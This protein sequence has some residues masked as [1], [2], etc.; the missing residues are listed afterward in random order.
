MTK[1]P[2]VPALLPVELGVEVGAKLLQV[3]EQVQDRP[4]TETLQAVQL[5]T[6]EEAHEGGFDGDLLVQGGRLL[7][8]VQDG[9]HD[10]GQA[11][12]AARM[13]VHVTAEVVEPAQEKKV[14][15][16]CQV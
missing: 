15:G 1:E 10:E 8:V 4:L 12:V 2:E 9:G 11:A 13:L 3:P 6:V 7:R 16:P 14:S 5:E